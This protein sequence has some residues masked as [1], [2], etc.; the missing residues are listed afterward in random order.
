MHFPVSV[1]MVLSSY[2]IE[3]CREYTVNHSYCATKACFCWVKDCYM[4][5]RMMSVMSIQSYHN[6][7]YSLRLIPTTLHRYLKTYYYISHTKRYLV[8]CY[9]LST[10]KA[11]RLGCFV[12]SFVDLV[13]FHH[14]SLDS[15]WD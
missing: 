14:N 4:N 2:V 1:I 12:V 13:A 10:A 6:A 5:D 9:Q 8:Q 7:N 15:F 11:F 3:A